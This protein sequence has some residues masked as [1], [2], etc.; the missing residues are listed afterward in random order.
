MERDGGASG[1]CA[2]GSRGQAGALGSGWSRTGVLRP[3]LK[4]RSAV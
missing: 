2:G 4:K 3:E 1:E